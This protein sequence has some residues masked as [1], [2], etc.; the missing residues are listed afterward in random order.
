MSALVARRSHPGTLSARK[1]GDL[2]TDA[3]PRPAG[4][5]EDIAVKAAAVVRS[6]AGTATDDVLA[7]LGLAVAS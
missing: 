7:M 1:P 6:R 2:R 4:I 3:A 5:T